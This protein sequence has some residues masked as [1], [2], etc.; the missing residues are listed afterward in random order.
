LAS[1]FTGLPLLFY[2]IIHEGNIEI[3]F[4]GGFS[5][6]LFTSSLGLFFMVLSDVFKIAKTM[7]DDNE[8]TVSLW[9]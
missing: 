1:L 4:G 5:S 8:L 9:V 2:K 7:T 6:F 3:E